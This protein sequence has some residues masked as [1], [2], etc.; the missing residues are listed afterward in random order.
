MFMISVKRERIGTLKDTRT[1]NVQTDVSKTKRHKLP[2]D[3][4]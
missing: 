4:I 2:N 3:L 1:E